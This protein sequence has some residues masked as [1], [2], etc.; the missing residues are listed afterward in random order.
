MTAKLRQPSRQNAQQTT[1]RLTVR[2]EASHG[3]YRYLALRVQDASQRFSRHVSR[4]TKR[5]L[6]TEK[7]GAYMM[8]KICLWQLSLGKENMC[9]TIHVR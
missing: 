3:V 6:E 4:Q 9:L 2:S 1:E 8:F 5:V 7:G